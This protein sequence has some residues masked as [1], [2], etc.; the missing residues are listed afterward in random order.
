MSR[1]ST[2]SP[3]LPV[4]PAIAFAAEPQVV[5][6]I[7]GWWRWLAYERR[8]SAHTL[9]AYARDLDAFLRFLARHLGFAPG[10]REL[11]ALRAADLRSYLADR[12]RRGIGRASTARAMSAIRG[13]FRFLERSHS[14]SNPA[15]RAIAAP[16][17]PATLPKPLGV[18]ATR[19]VLDSAGCEMGA[20]WVAKR[21]VALLTVLYGCGLRIG[22]ALALERGD[23]PTGRTMTITGKGRKQRLVPVLAVVREAVVDYLAA[24]PQPLSHDG[25]LFVGVRG[26][27]LNAGVV[28]R[29]MRKLRADLNLPE[30]AT[31]HA[32]RHSF[33]THLLEGGGDLRTIQELLGHASL[34]TTQRYT[35]VDAK[36]LMAV[37]RKA[38]PRA[39]STAVGS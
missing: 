37:Y 3:V 18:E 13:F 9:A 17:V 20:P 11:K 8:A 27:R 30:T 24:C 39:R 2:N 22:E 32:L 1:E 34:S 33:A 21:D 26:G 10:L 6:A 19:E 14:V 4:F 23:A 12:A 16:R 15:L 28:Q 5:A 35:A 25:P 29:L 38:H 31:P 7:E 36:H